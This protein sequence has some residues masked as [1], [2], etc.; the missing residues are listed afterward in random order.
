MANK[1][2]FSNSVVGGDTWWDMSSS[3]RDLYGALNMCADDEGFSTGARTCM[4][5]TGTDETNLTNLVEN[6][7]I[8]TFPNN[9]VLVRHWWI[10]NNYREQTCRPSKH[11][12]LFKDLT[13]IDGK[14]YLNEDITSDLIIPNDKLKHHNKIIIDERARQLSEETK[15]KTDRLKRLKDAGLNETDI[16]NFVN[17]N[18]NSSVNSNVPLEKN[19]TSI[20]PEDIPEDIPEEEIK[21]NNIKGKE[22]NS[23]SSG[24]S[25][26]YDADTL[27]NC[28]E[29]ILYGQHVSKKELMEIYNK[30][31][32]HFNSCLESLGIVCKSNDRMNGI[33]MLNRLDMMQENELKRQR[34]GMN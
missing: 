34:K 13:E 6:E 16:T 5:L 10:N 11:L 12:E 17:S 33:E 32:E 24:Y 27:L 2:M 31:P 21:E 7:Y 28:D 3:D 19:I 23:F 30:L 4:K 8:Y 22:E 1:R 25:S 15:E 29:P 14:Y 9:I 18:V 26:L 20:D